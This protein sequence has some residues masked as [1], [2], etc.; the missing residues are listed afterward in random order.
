[1]VLK[2]IRVKTQSVLLTVAAVCVVASACDPNPAAAQFEIPTDATGK[3]VALE[4]GFDVAG[5]RPLTQSDCLNG[6]SLQSE[7]KVAGCTKDR[8]VYG[9]NVR[10]HDERR[11]QK[12]SD[13][14][15]LGGRPIY[16]MR[17]RPDGSVKEEFDFLA[18]SMASYDDEGR[19]VLAA[20]GVKNMPSLAV[21]A[22]SVERTVYSDDG[23]A[24]VR[25]VEQTVDG[26]CEL[27]KIEARNE[28]LEAFAGSACDSRDFEG[29]LRKETKLCT[30]PAARAAAAQRKSAPQSGIEVHALDGTLTEI[31][32]GD[33]IAAHRLYMKHCLALGWK[34][35]E[36]RPRV[37]IASYEISA[38]GE[39]TDIDFEFPDIETPASVDDCMRKIVPKHAKFP[40]GDDSTKAT[41]AID[42][43]ASKRVMRKR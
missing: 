30:D 18:E 24:C 31:Q 25:Y 43:T 22:D 40:V 36:D 16:Q 35:K 23:A 4:L 27:T 10:W 41:V 14:L 6:A 8:K 26:A 29:A 3:E 42:L 38:G 32:I 5:K 37:M 13:L 34:A 33:A 15:A 7:G 12:S 1:M 2:M 19:V 17:W 28:A 21:V 39:V 9:R 20:T 11:T